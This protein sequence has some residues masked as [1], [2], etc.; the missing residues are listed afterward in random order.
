MNPDASNLE[1]LEDD[2]R[3]RRRINSPVVKDLASHNMAPDSPAVLISLLTKPMM[4]EKLRV[5]IMSLIGRMMDMT[6]W[7][8]E[9]E[10]TVMV[11]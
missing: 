11:Y 5:E 1:V 9:E 7:P 8:L 10:E 6:L 4:S 2:A 3:S